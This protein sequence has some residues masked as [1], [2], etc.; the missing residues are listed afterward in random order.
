MIV[1]KFCNKENVDVAK[2]CTQCGRK[3]D[4]DQ[5]EVNQEAVETQVVSDQVEAVQEVAEP[6]MQQPISDDQTPLSVNENSEPTGFKAFTAKHPKWFFVPTGIAAVVLIMVLAYN[7]VVG[8]NPVMK[9]M[10]GLGRL[11]TQNETNVTA[12]FTTDITSEVDD[13]FENVETKLSASVNKKKQTAAATA[14]F[15]FEDKKVFES[16]TYYNEG[17]LYF[18]MPDVLEEDEYLYFDANDYLDVDEETMA[19]VMEYVDMISMRGLNI[20]DYADVIYDAAEGNIEKDGN[21]VIYTIDGEVVADVLDEV[22][23]FAEDDE[24]LPNWVQENGITVLAKMDEDKFEYMDFDDDVIEEG[25]DLLDD[26]D[27][28]DD[29]MEGV[30]EL[31]DGMKYA[32]D[33]IEDGMED[34]E[35]EVVF[36]FGLFNSIKAIDI[37]FEQGRQGVTV[38]M[39]MTKG[40]KVARKYNDD[41]GNDV[42]RM[43]PDDVE[44]IVADTMDYFEDYMDEN[45]EFEDFLLDYL[46]D[47]TGMDDM[48]LVFDMLTSDLMRE[49]MWE[50]Y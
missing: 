43:D 26:K 23:S 14:T 34:V 8:G 37:T 13:F 48:D 41:D 4:R 17:V 31:A 50:F 27:F 24:K 16:L 21:K 2:I 40:A 19:S 42:E 30:E 10:I 3:L 18:D 11:Y 39:D 9:T 46:E 38:S 35:L 49:I 25:L 7:V 20:K 33:E 36:T 6:V 28:V 29:W 22:I 1:C 47:V 5:S 45:E 32:K 12:T 44:D 15:S